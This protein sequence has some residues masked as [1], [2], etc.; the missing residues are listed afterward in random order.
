MQDHT[1][2]AV[3]PKTKT[4][5]SQ[6]GEMIT[7]HVK[8]ND[9]D[10]VVQLNK[11]QDSPTPKIGDQVYGEIQDTEYGQKFKAAKKPFTPNKPGYS[12]DDSAIRAQWAIGQSMTHH[13]GAEQLS[14]TDIEATATALYLMVDR[15]KVADPTMIAKQEVK[16]AKDVVHTNIDMDAPINLEDIPF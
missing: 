15:V 7:Y 8:L 4:W 11:K 1:I 6:Y 16:P 12:R 13:N 10:Q 14:L 5:S 2:S 3:S 9:D